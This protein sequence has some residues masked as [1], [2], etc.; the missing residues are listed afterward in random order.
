MRPCR[1]VF[2]SATAK[3][4]CGSPVQP[5]EFERSRFA[6]TGKPI[7]PSARRGA[8]RPSATPVTTRFCWRVTRTSR[9]C[10]SASSATA[11]IWSPEIRP[12][13]TGTPNVLRRGSCSFSAPM[14]SAGSWS[15]G[16]SDVVGER[17]A[18]PPLDLCAHALGAVVVDHELEARLHARD[19]VAE[20]LLPGVEERAEDGQ[21]LVDADPHAELARDPRHGGEA[22]AD[23][24]REPGLA[25]ADGADEGD[26][27]D[28]RRVAAVGAG[29]DRD[30]V[31]AGEVGVVRVAVEE[32]G[33]LVL[34]SGHVEELVVREP[35]DGAAG[36]VADGVA[37][38]PDRRQPDRGSAVETVG[39][40]AEL[41]V[42][43]LDRL[44]RRQLA[45]AAA[46]LVRELADRPQLLRRDA[47]GGK[48]DPEHEGADLR[49]VVVEAP[50]LEPDEVLLL[51][52]GIAGRDQGGQLGQHRERA[53][54]PLQALDRVPLEDELERRRLLHPLRPCR[55]RHPT[56]LPTR[57]R[58]RPP[59]PGAW[60]VPAAPALTI[61]PRLAP[62]WALAA[63]VRTW[64]TG[65]PVAAV[66]SGQFPRPLVMVNA[67]VCIA[68]SLHLC[69]RLQSR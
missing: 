10:V 54:R 14:W 17:V 13:W 59:I 26:A 57:K 51:D 45:R 52:V 3:L 18:E 55:L 49:L 43:K 39:Q 42:M 46:V 48:L 2:V 68:T 16:S 6:S 15:S 67:F 38:G 69:K 44:A 22:A 36:Q 61:F 12:R 9:P 47:A 8:R 20:V 24:H 21:R 65:V 29:G 5:I 62:G 1:R 37:A 35:G 33:H 50:P 64:R 11:I 7:S 28:L 60:A 66:S 41:E 58:Q 53:L 31:L 25:V 56:C 4:Q 40:G 23:E 63:G 34:Q 19:P 27:V 32:R 30:L